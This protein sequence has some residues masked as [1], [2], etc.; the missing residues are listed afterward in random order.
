M[1]D[2]NYLGELE[3]WISSSLEKININLSSIKN[4]DDA[5]LAQKEIN[6]FING[7]EL[8][9]QEINIHI[10]EV[11]IQF[12]EEEP[13]KGLFSQRRRKDIDNDKD[14]VL[15]IWQKAKAALDK[16][17]NHMNEVKLEL[18]RQVREQS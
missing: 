2:A 14:K 5:K 3:E 4:L 17:I 9:K 8:K 10:K 11:R 18:E 12:D 6:Q 7:L 15:L 13:S 16:Q 1:L